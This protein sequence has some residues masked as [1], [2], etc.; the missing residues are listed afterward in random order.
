MLNTQYA[1]GMAARELETGD[2]RAYA[3]WLLTTTTGYS[4]VR[5]SL[6]L[7]ALS[8]SLCLVV[9]LLPAIRKAALFT[10]VSGPRADS[11][12]ESLK[13]RKASYRLTASDE[14][15]ASRLTRRSTD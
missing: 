5:G 3:E 1:R 6:P 9:D 13:Q 10:C 4:R 11:V 7:L 14:N 2:E 12:T 8:T 15:G